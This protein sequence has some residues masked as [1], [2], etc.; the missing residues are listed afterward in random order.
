MKKSFKKIWKFIW[1]DD[2][3][4]SFIINIILAFIIVKFLI[5][6]GLGFILGTTH[7]LVAVVSG[8]MEHDGLSFNDWWLNNKAWYE[9]HGIIKEDFSSYKMKNGFNKGDIIVLRKASN[10]RKGDIIVFRSKSINPIIHRIVDVYEDND[11]IYYKTKG[12][13]NPDSITLL[14]EDKISQENIIGKAY[15][16]IPYLG[17]LKVWFSEVTGVA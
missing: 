17:W 7:P 5:Y 14:G 9:N 16:K 2:S 3:A 6:P 8:S 10:L 11:V 12:D 13:D 1:H 15:F 4:L